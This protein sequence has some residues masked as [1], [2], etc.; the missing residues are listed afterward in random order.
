MYHRNILVE[1]A[2]PE[3]WVAIQ[4]ENARQEHIRNWQSFKKEKSNF[5]RRACFWRDDRSRKGNACDYGRWREKNLQYCH[6]II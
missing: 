6:A 2:D 3:V 4:A 5:F 1:Q